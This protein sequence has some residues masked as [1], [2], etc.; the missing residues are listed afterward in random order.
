MEVISLALEERVFF[1]MQ[2]NVKVTGR[3]PEI[4]SFSQAGIADARAVFHPSGNFGLDLSFFQY[5]T[6]PPTLGTWV[7]DHGAATLTGRACAGDAEETLLVANLAATTTASAGYRSFA[8]CGPGSAALLADLVPAYR[9]LCF[10]S[11]DR[12]FEFQADVFSQIGSPLRAAA[13]APSSTTTTTTKKVPKPEEVAKDIA[14]ILED[15]GI[16]S[17]S[18][19]GGADTSVTESVVQSTLL[20]IRQNGV[21]FAALFELLFRIRVIRIAVGMVLQRQLAICALDLDVRSRAAYAQN[22]VV[23]TFAVGC[24]NENT[25]KKFLVSSL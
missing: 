4:T 3:A 1:Y 15:A 19:G 9:D 22:F 20:L 8:G 18:R 14:E 13:T 10:G 2:H 24:R 11:K 25:P 23:I 12:F 5:S 17:G 16:E 21:R 7:G 6:F